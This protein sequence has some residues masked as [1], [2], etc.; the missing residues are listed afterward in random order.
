M[1]QPRLQSLKD[2]HSALEARIGME[3]QRPLPDSLALGR[4]KREKLR[5]KEEMERLRPPHRAI[6]HR[7]GEHRPGA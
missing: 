6:E 5:L 2:R 3:A 7:P 4:L 1:I